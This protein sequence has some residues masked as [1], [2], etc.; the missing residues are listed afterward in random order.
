MI[1][2]I[3]KQKQYTA[4]KEFEFIL[5]QI[6]KCY[7]LMLTDYSIIENDEN[8]IR[9][10][11]HKDYLDNQQILEQF[12]LQAYFFD[13]E[14]P[15]VDKNYKETARSDI[16]IYDPIERIQNRK[17][18]YFIIECKRLDGTNSGKGSLNYKYV[19]NGIKRFTSRADY[20][21]FFGINGM[22][23]FVL[24]T[25]EIVKIVN[26]INHLL[27]ENENLNSKLIGEHFEFSYLSK[28]TDYQDKNIKLYH[29]MLDFSSQIKK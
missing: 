2:G 27:P 22:I 26:S 14:T 1:A 16:K 10:R 18:P 7:K 25:K 23:G 13:I 21:T 19:E 20:P 29:L 8:I 3:F 15:Y 5:T 28:H 12:N 11:L 24:K 6:T 4:R 17:S 9:N